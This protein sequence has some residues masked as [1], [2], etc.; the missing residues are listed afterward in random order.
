MD[1]TEFYPT[2][3]SYLFSFDVDLESDASAMRTEREANGQG[4]TFVAGHAHAFEEGSMTKKAPVYNVAGDSRELG[5]RSIRGHVR[6]LQE[7]VSYPP[8]HEFGE[9]GGRLVIKTNDD[10]SL[11]GTYSGVFRAGPEWHWLNA[12]AAAQPSDQARSKAEKVVAKAFISMQFDVGSTKYAWL[13]RHQCVGYG[14]LD[15]KLGCPLFA[16]FDI[17][18]LDSIS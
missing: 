10:D 4:A 17:Y 6:L 14:R 1:R 9:L 7:R 12:A 3:T 16:T 2:C 8:G 13:A 5:E 11:E 18:A 15:L